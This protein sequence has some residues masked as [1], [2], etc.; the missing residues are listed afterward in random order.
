MENHDLIIEKLIK[1]VQDKKANIAE[2]EKEKFSY[3][4][5]CQIEIDGE[6]Y[7][8][9][10]SNEEKLVT[11]TSK[12]LLMKDAQT[13]A[14][15][16]LEIDDSCL[17]IGGYTLTEWLGD[18]KKAYTEKKIAKQKKELISMENDLENMYSEGKKIGNKLTE[19]AK[20]LKK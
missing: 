15:E 14:N 7:N 5:N 6:R 10:V 8:L 4:T 20:I 13:K 18:I 16:F 19:F 9:R 17:E 1:K 12:L 11:L 2:L 3:V